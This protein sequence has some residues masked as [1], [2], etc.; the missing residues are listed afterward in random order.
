MSLEP[1]SGLWIS[2]LTTQGKSLSLMLGACDD[3]ANTN[4]CCVFELL[5]F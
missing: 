4:A 1:R 5:E 3:A 2:A